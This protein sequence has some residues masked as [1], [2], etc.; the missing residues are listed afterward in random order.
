[1]SSEWPMQDLGSLI[2]YKKGFAFKSKDYISAGVPI[3]R[4][5][6]FTD[7][8]ISPNDLKFVSP[9]IAKETPEVSLEVNDIVVAT[10]GSWPNNPASVVGRTI[11]VPAWAERAL[12]NQNSV[13]IRAKSKSLT[14]QKFIYYQ[15][16]SQDFSAHVVSKAQGSANQ[17]SITLD[18]IF[19]YRLFWPKVEHRDVIVT[20]LSHLDDRIA[21]LRETNVTLEAIAQALFKSWFV[22]FDPV[23]ARARGEQPAGL[24]P[25]VAALFPDSFEESALGMIPRGWDVGVLGDV[26]ET[27]RKQIKPEQLSAETLYVGLEHIPRKQL[28]LDSWGT[29]GE[30]ASAKSAFERNDILFG[31]L[32]PY[33][34]KVVIAPFE[35]VCSTDILVCKAKQTAYHHYVAMHLFSDELIAYADRLSNGAKMPRINWK[36]LAAYEVAIPPSEVAEQFYILIEPMIARML[37]NVEQAQTLANLRDTLLPR[38]VSGQLRLPDAEQQLKDLAV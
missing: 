28:G 20:F 12:M 19:S 31:K 8:S 30:L 21:L 3:V 2:S 5:S 15:M 10:V 16:R 18:A 25:E 6:N 26:S 22:D 13:I 23:H 24:A 34:H 11:R 14:D 27:S 29:A 35:G 7:D 4:V 38:L 1:M 32:R 17:A 37:A 33:F 9:D 36:D